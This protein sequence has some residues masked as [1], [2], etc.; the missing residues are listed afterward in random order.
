MSPVLPRLFLA[1]AATL[2]GLVGLELLLRLVGYDPLGSWMRE[3]GSG[4]VVRLSGED[5]RYELVPLAE[6]RAWDANVKINSHGFRDKEYPLQKGERY[7]IVVIGDSITFGIGLDLE[8]TYPELLEESLSRFARPVDVLNLGVGGY[9]AVQDVAQLE[10]SGLRFAPDLV[11]LGFCTND[12]GDY[13][14]N[15]EYLER[16]HQLESEIYRLRLAQFV[17]VFSD[18]ISALYLLLAGT[19]EAE[20]YEAKRRYIRALDGDPELLAMIEAVRPISDQGRLFGF[21]PNRHGVLSWWASQVHVGMLDYAFARLARLQAEWGFDTLV[22]ILPWL[23]K[24]EAWD[25]VYRIVAHEARKFELPTLNL[26]PTLA[27]EGFASLRMATH[28]RLHPNARGHRLI[29]RALEEHL[30]ASGLVEELLEGAE[31]LETQS[32]PRG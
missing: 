23:E 8:E 28:D 1:A 18:R 4:R 7:R 15:E 13:S 24:G 25:L 16:L 11:I 9:D 32:V 12:I 3:K 21:I 19:S 30:L 26:A 10:H 27:A 5:L 20:F 29:A 22:V 2:T 31:V 6:N 14:V 17:K